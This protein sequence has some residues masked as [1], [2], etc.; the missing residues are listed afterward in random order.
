LVTKQDKSS[1]LFADY[2][3]DW[4]ETY[5]AGA[6]RKATLLKYYNTAKWVRKLIPAVRMNEL[7]RQ[8]YQK[9]LNEFAKTHEKQT[10]RDLNTQIKACIQD[11]LHEGDLEKDPTYKVVIKGKEESEKKMKFLHGEELRK[12]ICVL[13][14]G[15][16]INYDWLILLL[17]KTGLRFSEALGLTPNDFNFEEKTLTVNKTWNYKYPEGGFAKTK[18]KAS[19]RTISIDSILNSQF[20]MLT[21]DMAPDKLIFV[22]SNKRVFNS[23]VNEV[24]ERKCKE[25][26]VP[27]ISL[28]S[29]RHTHASMLLTAG[30]SI[31]SIAAR[32][33]HANVTTTQRVY[34]HILKELEAKDNDKLISQLE[35]LG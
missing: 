4:I 13:D 12:L 29:L 23:T 15:T 31:H 9:F 21:K 16:Q 34:T 18:N 1:P 11:A 10:T 7:D 35:K 24:L 32:L 8:T 3:D 30:I 17:A 14:L 19:I 5:K 6:I 33:G 22:D 20:K 2:F 27:V 28:H 26:G 25:A